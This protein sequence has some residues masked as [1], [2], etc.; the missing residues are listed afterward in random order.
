MLSSSFVMGAYTSQCDF[1]GKAIIVRCDGKVLDANK[2]GRFFS[3]NGAGSSLEVHGCTLKNGRAS[4]SVVPRLVINVTAL[5][6]SAPLLVPGLR[7]LL[8][9]CSDRLQNVSSFALCCCLL[10]KPDEEN[11]LL[12]FWDVFP[13]PTSELLH[14]G[15]FWTD[16]DV[17]GSTDR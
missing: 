1:S 7:V 3:G 16:W 2:Q 5:L 11:F 9:L 8:G 17:V 10:S 13:Y 12:C 15:R 4:V 14:V 6:D